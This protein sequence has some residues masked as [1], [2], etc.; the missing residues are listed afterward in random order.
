MKRLGAQALKTDCWAK[1]GAD[2]TRALVRF[3]LVAHLASHL[4][5]LTNFW[6][7]TCAGFKVSDEMGLSH[8]CNSEAFHR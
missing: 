1:V 8:Y 2:G 5:R 4:C 3:G 7:V 6:L